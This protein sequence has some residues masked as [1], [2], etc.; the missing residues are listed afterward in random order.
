VTEAQRSDA[1]AAWA[2]AGL[3]ISFEPTL[4]ALIELLPPPPLDVLDVGCGEGRFGLELVRRGYEVVG[5]DVEP[6]MVELASEHHRALVA[7][8]TEL[9]FAEAAFPC[10]VSVHVLMEIEDLE[11]AVAEISRVVQPGGALVA[12]VE[13]PFAS[14]AKVERYSAPARYMWPVTHEGV[15]LALGGIHR[16]LGMYLSSL[17]AAG[18]QVDRLREISVGRWDPMSLAFR[19]HKV[20]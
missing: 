6:R 10:V 9:P 14:G 8:A 7:E 20:R 11:L 12:V 19:A 4:A 1:Y 3:D 16:P 13:H 2:R 18:L 15:D 17:E 5:V